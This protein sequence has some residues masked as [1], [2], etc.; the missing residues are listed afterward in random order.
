M[1]Q[2]APPL[3]ISKQVMN[4]DAATKHSTEVQRKESQEAAQNASAPHAR[5]GGR[6]RKGRLSRRRRRR[7]GER[8]QGGG[9]FR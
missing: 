2:A 1:T 4:M 5:G 8:Q 3:L 9:H 6:K 7:G